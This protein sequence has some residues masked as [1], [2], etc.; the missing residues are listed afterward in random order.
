MAKPKLIEGGKFGKI[1]YVMDTTHSCCGH[2]A[3]MNLEENFLPRYDAGRGRINTGFA[4]KKEQLEQFKLDIETDLD[5]A[6]NDHWEE[7]D[8]KHG[9]CYGLLS[10]TLI[11]DQIEGLIDYMVDELKWSKLMIS[12]NPKTDN[13]LVHLGVEL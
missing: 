9:W 13:K 6:G 3:I 5:D 12:T 8:D 1:T 10:C 7:Y 11:E 2:A 4:T